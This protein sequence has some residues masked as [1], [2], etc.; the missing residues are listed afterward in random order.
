[1]RDEQL[2][3]RISRTYARI[4]HLCHPR[5]TFNLPHQAVRALQLIGAERASIRDLAAHLGVA[6]NTA[7]ELVSRLSRRGLLVK[8]RDTEDERSVTLYLTELGQRALHEQT[9]LDEKKLRVALN[10]MSKA[11]RENLT[12]GL[13]A[14]LQ[15]L[16]A[17]R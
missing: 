7:S 14:L 16:E 9:G 8:R 3:E 2:A 12:A 10:A 1:M 5:Y 6:H 4:Y 13:S 11:E 17:Q 15:E